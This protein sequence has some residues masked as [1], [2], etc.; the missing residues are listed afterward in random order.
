VLLQFGLRVKI[1]S[2]LQCSATN[3]KEG[4]KRVIYFWKEISVAEELGG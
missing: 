1:N 3:E 4:V 2:I